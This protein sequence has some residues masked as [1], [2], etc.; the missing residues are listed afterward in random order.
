[1]K[2]LEE[3]PKVPENKEEAKPALTNV[4]AGFACVVGLFNTIDLDFR[5]TEA[6]EGIAV[7]G[8]SAAVGDEQIFVVGL[9]DGGVAIAAAFVIL[10]DIQRSK[11]LTIGA[12]SKDKGSSA[13]G[14]FLIDASVIVGD[15]V[16]DRVGDAVV[17]FHLQG[18][19]RRGELS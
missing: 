16:I 7:L 12:F 6:A 8:V 2:L 13:P 11:I 17:F 10:N 1:M 5:D 15:G 3:R 19:G 18:R 9:E 4:S 14:S